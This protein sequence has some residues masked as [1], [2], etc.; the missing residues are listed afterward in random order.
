RNDVQGICDSLTYSAR[1]SILNMHGGPVLWAEDNQ[2]SG[3]FIQA[4]TKNEKVNKI[5]I[6]RVAVAIQHQDSV[7]Y[8]Q[9]SGKE[10]IA[11]VDS[12]QLKKVD[13]NGNAETIYYPVD[14]KDST[15]I[16]L[17]KTKS[18]F[19]VMYLKNK[20]VERVVMTSATTGTM[21]P[22][23]QLSGGELYLKN[24]FWLEDQRPKSKK[25]LFQVFPKVARPKPGDDNA[26]AAT[27]PK[28]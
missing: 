16:G 11:Y 27:P 19:V 2:L 28:P 4:F 7:Y 5:H 8:N 6:Q 10:I 24:F 3:E 18:S 23:A 12:N 15:L 14:D 17:N 9:L 25:D 20:K 21:Y 26:A 13:V 22:L 1:D